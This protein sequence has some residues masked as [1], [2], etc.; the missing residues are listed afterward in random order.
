MKTIRRIVVGILAGTFLASVVACSGVA[1]D[2]LPPAGAEGVV[3]S[4]D[5]PSD[6]VHIAISVEAFR[7]AMRAT[8]VDGETGLARM[9]S[10]GKLFVVPPRTKVL[11]LQPMGPT[12]TLEI[13]STKEK[14]GTVLTKVQILEG[15]Y[16]G[17]KG[18]LS[19]DGVHCK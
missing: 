11:V 3:Y 14:A 1:T 18:F 15:K 6:D 17:T 9:V 19:S 12:V 8:A 5:Y 10:S 16:K 4:G 2:G 13:T 7:E